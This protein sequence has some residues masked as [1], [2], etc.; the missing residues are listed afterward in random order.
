MTIF[1][2]MGGALIAAS[3]FASLLWSAQRVFAT[4]GRTRTA[5][6]LLVLAIIA[7]MA[8]LSAEAPVPTQAMGFLLI[9][10]A[11]QTGWQDRGWSRLLCLPPV[12]LGAICVAGLPFQAS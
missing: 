11:V 7:T 10:A 5:H 2:L 9:L 8:A 6:A 12:A 4:T 1:I 3:L